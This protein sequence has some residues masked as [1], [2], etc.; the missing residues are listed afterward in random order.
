MTCENSV[1]K[2]NSSQ[3]LERKK[4]WTTKVWVKMYLPKKNN[5]CKKTDKFNK[6]VKS[7]SFTL[8]DKILKKSSN[9]CLYGCTLF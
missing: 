1:G 4:S 8:T 7:L 6:I 5:N 2:N 3:D 9:H